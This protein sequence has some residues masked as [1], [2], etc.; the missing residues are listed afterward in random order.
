MINWAHLKKSRIIFFFFVSYI[1]SMARFRKNGFFKWTHFMWILKRLQRN[2]FSFTLPYAVLVVYEQH[3][4]NG[5]TSSEL[6]QRFWIQQSHV[7]IGNQQGCKKF[8]DIYRRISLSH[9]FSSLLLRKAKYCWLSTL[10]KKTS[11]IFLARTPACIRSLWYV[12]T[13]RIFWEIRK[14]RF[15]IIYK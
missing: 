6:C 8:Q 1:L 15:V 11:V 7:R 13:A 3:I 14:I 9:R 10:S 12:W 2:Y 4:S 5:T